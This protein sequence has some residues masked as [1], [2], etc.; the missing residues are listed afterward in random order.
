MTAPGRE[1]EDA[2]CAGCGL[3][4][5]GTLHAKADLEPGEARLLGSAGL[6]LIDGGR[7]FRMPC[8]YSKNGCCSVFSNRPAAVCSSY[9]CKLLRSTKNGD[10]T[11]EAAREKVKTAIA[12]RAKVAEHNPDAVLAEHRGPLW[13]RLQSALPSLEPAARRSAAQTI[14]DI[15]V[16]DEFL[17]RWFGNR[18]P[19]LGTESSNS[20]TD[21][22]DR[23]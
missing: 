20:R 15:A 16:L 3:C 4:C 23:R 18:K 1:I 14:L 11:V 13:K 6:E 10:L 21:E 2:L 17:D 12:L 7:A 8:P 19:K 9:E 22:P 5:D